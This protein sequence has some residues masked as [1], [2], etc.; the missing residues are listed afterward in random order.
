MFEKNRQTF[1]VNRNRAM[2]AF[3]AGRMTIST[4]K[5]EGFY[6]ICDENCRK[7]SQ[8]NWCQIKQAMRSILEQR[9]EVSL[10]GC[11]ADHIST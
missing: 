10:K 1:K 2:S 6:S 5:T 3:M 7:I 9:N 11:E 8:F 4:M